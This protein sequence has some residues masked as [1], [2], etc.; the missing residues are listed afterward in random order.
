MSKYEPLTQRIYGF[1]DLERVP[2]WELERTIKM[3]VERLEKSRVSATEK[4]K[5]KKKLEKVLKA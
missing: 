4:D 1:K 5:H 2:E 3:W